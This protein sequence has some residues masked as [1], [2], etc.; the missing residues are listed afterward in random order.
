MAPLKAASAQSV[1][2]DGTIVVAN[3][4]EIDMESPPTAGQSF[5]TYSLIGFFVLFVIFIICITADSMG[6]GIIRI[7]KRIVLAD[8]SGHSS[9][10][11]EIIIFILVCV[12]IGVYLSHAF[13]TTSPAIEPTR[14]TP[15][16]VVS[17]MFTVQ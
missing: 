12:F 15:V 11:T 14:T 8:G 16:S 3:S 1:S 2:T 10:I 4:N 17:S 9:M 7:G 13:A 6:R 5:L